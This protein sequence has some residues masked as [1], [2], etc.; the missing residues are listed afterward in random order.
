MGLQPSP[1]PKYRGFNLVLTQSKPQWDPN[2]VLTLILTQ[3]KPQ[4]DSQLSPNPKY[5]GFNLILTQ[6]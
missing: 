5:I 3:F 4:W 2:S 1:N 6:S